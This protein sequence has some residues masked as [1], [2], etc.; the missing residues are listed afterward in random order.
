MELYP[1]KGGHEVR[2]II[3]GVF[4]VCSFELEECFP[5][6]DDEDLGFV[7]VVDVGKAVRFEFDLVQV[8]IVVWQSLCFAEVVPLSAEG[9]PEAGWLEV[10]DVA[11][12]FGWIEF[13]FSRRKFAAIRELHHWVG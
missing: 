9:V 3:D 13:D 8:S 2:P 1:C 7:R 10:D 5:V 12:T 6:C 4:E 11:V